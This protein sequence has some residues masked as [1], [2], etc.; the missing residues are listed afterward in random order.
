MAIFPMR[1]RVPALA[2]CAGIASAVVAGETLSNGI[3]L[4]DAWPPQVGELTRA[5]LATP[6]YLTAPPAVIPIDVGRQLFVDDFLIE[7][8]TL[9]RTHHLPKYH[10]ACPVFGPD[11]PWEGKGARMRAGVFSD[12][13]WFDPQDQLF[14]AWYWSGAVSENPLRYATCYTVSKDGIH[15][16]KPLLDVV[17]GTNIVQEDEDDL[18]RNSGTVWLDHFEKDAAKRFKMFRVVQQSGKDGKGHRNFI[19]YSASADGI[20]W[21][22]VADSADCGDRSTVFFNAHRQRW[23]AGLREGGKIVSRCRGYYEAPDA[24]GMVAFGN[25]Q[26]RNHEVK[27]WIGAD[28]LD[29]SREDLKLRRTE[30]RPWDLVP[31]QLYNLDCIA[32][33]SVML[34]MFTI[35]RGQPADEV[36]RPKINEVCVGF[37]RDGFHWSR[38][39]RRAFCPVSEDPKAWN[40][41]NVQSAGGCC[42][43]VGDRLYFYV[44]GVNWSGPSRHADPNNTGLAILRRDGFASLDADAG[45]GAVTTRPV[46]FSGSHL[47]ANVA[48]PQG[49]LR[50]EVLDEKG[51]VIAPFTTANC[52]PIAHTDGTKLELTWQGA[53]DLRTL[54]ARTVKLRFTLTT[55][56]LYAFWISPDTNGASRGYVAAGGP[57]FTGATD[58]TGK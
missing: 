58:A 17:P 41:G 42:L 14:K 6:P 10:D 20:H 48:V 7:T 54:A 29:P 1:L 43:V 50:A 15:W 13:V 8:T 35:W 34:G 21:K 23:V 27:F 26:T 9:K 11:Q 36:K 40:F 57:G 53:A 19:R 18:R 55:G 47:F 33:E 51:A 46:Q 24:A 56:Q 37:S 32:Y 28:E 44:G 3:V 16:E 2:L 25:P 12:G 22:F 39:D 5:P 31:S 45:G 49:E 52:R 4:P 38:P 30:N